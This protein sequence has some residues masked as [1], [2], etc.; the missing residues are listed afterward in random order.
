[1]N[2]PVTAL[3]IFSGG[4][5]SILAAL[6][7]R[8]QGIAV[9]CLCFVTPFFGAERAEEA[10]RRYDLS[11]TVRDISTVHLQMLKNPHYGYG[12]NLNPCIDCHALMF[13]LADELRQE[14][15]W[16]FLFSG[17]VLGQRP[18]S[19]LRPAL[20]AVD[21]ASGCGSRILRPLSALLLPETAMER[22]GLVDR[23]QLRGISGRSRKPQEQLAA[24]LGVTD[25]PSS[26]GGCL[27][28]EPSFTV[29]LRDLFDHEPECTPADI[30]LL[31]QGR[32]FRLSPQA[33]L[34]LGRQRG[35][36]ERLRA[37]AL[38]RHVQLRCAECSGPLGVL[39]AA[40]VPLAPQ[41]VQLAAALV[42]SYGKDQAK[43]QVAVRLEWPDGRVEVLQVA[44][45]ARERAQQLQL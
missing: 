38:Q 39:V 36:N 42:A 7:L 34:A 35:D 5:D 12:R 13:R 45:L 3:G 17:E 19:Q 44:P 21:K 2:R 9:E 4:L 40:A 26:G 31:K 1:M 10:A 25:Y 43:A 30:A 27:L 28:T 29:R 41:D 16:D 18:K 14:R 20:Q 24:E 8:Q 11:L 33:R 6:L 15:G 22:D 23:T 32:A 37:L